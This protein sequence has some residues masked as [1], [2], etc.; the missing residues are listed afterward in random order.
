MIPLRLCSLSCSMP[1]LLVAVLNVCLFATE[2][3]IAR[4]ATRYQP[5]G[6]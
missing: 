3:A 1:L 6:D 2:E 5:S 4:V